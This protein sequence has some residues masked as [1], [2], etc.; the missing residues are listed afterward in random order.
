[1]GPQTSNTNLR[2]EMNSMRQQCWL[3]RGQF[4]KF[5][6]W[7]SSLKVT[8]ESTKTIHLKDK[9]Y[10]R[11]INNNSMKLLIHLLSLKSST[12]L[13]R[14]L[15]HML[16]KVLNKKTMTVENIKQGCLGI[17][18]R[19]KCKILS[20]VTSPDSSNTIIISTLNSMNLAQLWKE[21]TWLQA[22]EKVVWAI[23]QWQLLDKLRVSNNSSQ[24]PPQATSILKA[25]YK[26]TLFNNSNNSLVSAVTWS[27]MRM[28]TG[29]I[30]ATC[31]PPISLLSSL[32]TITPSGNIHWPQRTSN[33]FTNSQTS[34]YWY[35]LLPQPTTRNFLFM[36]TKFK[37][38]GSSLTKRESSVRSA[39][40][41]LKI[42]I[43]SFTKN[44]MTS[45]PLSRVSLSSILKPNFNRWTTLKCPT[46]PA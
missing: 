43:N 14:W 6:H 26:A 13:S 7:I 32:Q 46:S 15:S 28:K 17:I 41:N 9:F 24:E 23:K 33:F 8:L 31:L 35:R 44:W 30:Q 19:I 27:M 42:C 39:S 37:R 11:Q 16:I 12:S 45:R 10:T 40:S 34:A 21:R 2:L 3:N 36:I 29:S 4:K 22:N 1:M 25:L 20:R 38:K 18:T 5:L